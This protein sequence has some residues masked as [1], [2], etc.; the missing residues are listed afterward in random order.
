MLFIV[1]ACTFEQY[2]CSCILFDVD[3]FYNQLFTNFILILKYV[4][5]KH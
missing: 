1:E 4:Q 5:S 3:D 2:T